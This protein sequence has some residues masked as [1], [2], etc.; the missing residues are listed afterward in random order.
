[1]NC[2]TIHKNLIFFLGNELPENE[3]EQIKSHI[4]ECDGCALFLEDLQKTLAVIDEEKM[5]ESNPFLYSR[6]KVK[7]NDYGEKSPAQGWLTQ[8]KPALQPIAFSV[9]LALG[10]YSGFKIGK[11]GEQAGR[12]AIAQQEMIPYLNEMEVEPLETFLMD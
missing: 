7:L 4:T 3:M 10:I 12:T 11:P 5:L 2:K 8:L 1:M 9:L 6:L